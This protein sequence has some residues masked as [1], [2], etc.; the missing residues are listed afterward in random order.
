MNYFTSMEYGEF[1]AYREQ[2]HQDAVINDYN[3]VIGTKKARVALRN[4]VATVLRIFG[5]M[6]SFRLKDV[7]L[8]AVGLDPNDKYHR[9]QVDWAIVDL[10]RGKII[11]VVSNGDGSNPK[12]NKTYAI[13]GE[14]SPATAVTIS[15]EASR[16]V[17]TTVSATIADEPY[18]ADLDELADLFH[19]RGSDIS[20][21]GETL[22]ALIGCSKV[23]RACKHCYATSFV[24]R[25][26]HERHRGLAENR[27]GKDV[28]TGE[29]RFFPEVLEKPKGWKKPRLIFQTSLS[30]PFHEKLSLEVIQRNLDA[31]AET[32]QHIFQC[33]TKRP[34]RAAKLA[35]QL[36]WPDN[37]WVGATIEE[38]KEAWRADAL[39]D[40]PVATKFVSAEPLA[41]DDVAALDLT[42]ISWLIVGGESGHGAEPMHPDWARSLRDRA[43]DARVP[44]FF[45][46]WG[47]FGPDVRKHNRKEGDN[48]TLLDGQK[49]HQFPRVALHHGQRWIGQKP[50]GAKRVPPQPA[51]TEA[52]YL[53][54]NG[55]A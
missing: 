10:Q 40:I 1:A 49:W 14:E 54:L 23:S 22:N 42:D 29:V 20:W 33:L 28:W 12:I 55:E 11:E 50:V 46:Q 45:K 8:E 48:D 25:G 9:N 26:L 13:V 21:T 36:R 51:V 24:R 35:H 7:I 5:P 34:E 53:D 18:W 16:T 4:I 38:S 19:W 43:L 37:M 47:K 41:V 2:L 30:D 6:P 17:A 32:P 44:F 39:R 15:P 31:M 27:G 3:T 52:T